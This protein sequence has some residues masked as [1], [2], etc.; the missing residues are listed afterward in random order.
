MAM[1]LSTATA[2]AMLTALTALCNG[3][4]LIIYSGGVPATAGTA[5]NSG[6][7]NTVLADITLANPA[8]GSPAASGSNRVATALGVPVSDSGADNSG[9]AS[10]F[11]VYKSTGTALA[12]VVYQGAAGLA[13]AN[14]ELTL[15]D[16]GIIQGGT[17]S[18]SSLTVTQPTA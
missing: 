10:F 5:L 6:T 12:D 13:A 1:M 18:I 11:R 3:G 17:V 16:T 7:T 4:K 14:P 8:F 15:N 9:T 2:D